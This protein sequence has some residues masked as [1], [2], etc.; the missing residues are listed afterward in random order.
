MPDVK[1]IRH[2]VPAPAPKSDTATA[3]CGA[4][5]LRNPVPVAPSD[6]LCAACVLVRLNDIAITFGG[7]GLA[8]GW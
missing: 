6:D 2:L 1:K 3:L 5:V 8:V 7:Q 4:L